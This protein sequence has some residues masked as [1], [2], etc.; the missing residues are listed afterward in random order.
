[1]SFSILLIPFC[2]N[3]L[4]RNFLFFLACGLLEAVPADPLSSDYQIRIVRD[5]LWRILAAISPG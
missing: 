4:R 1:V 5:S 3:F 2:Y